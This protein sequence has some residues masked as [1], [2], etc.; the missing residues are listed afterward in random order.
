MSPPAGSSPY[1]VIVRS[2][3][4]GRWRSISLTSGILLTRCHPLPSSIRCSAI[5]DPTAN[6]SYP[7]A[8]R[9]RYDPTF[10]CSSF[11]IFIIII[12]APS[13]NQP[14]PL[15]SSW[16]CITFAQCLR[17][18]ASPPPR[19]LTRSTAFPWRWLT[20]LRSASHPCPSVSPAPGSPPPAPSSESGFP[21][22]YVANIVLSNPSTLALPSSPAPSPSRNY[23]T[24]ANLLLSGISTMGGQAPAAPPVVLIQASPLSSVNSHNPSQTS[25]SHMAGRGTHGRF[26]L[27]LHGPTH[28]EVD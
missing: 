28:Q 2:C 27:L 23:S 20:L 17:C 8:L 11:N 22:L 10:D 1:L 9:L 19:W 3:D 6:K 25:T 24:A 4:F 7:T 5:V 21:A 12:S 13:P 18:S 26:A 14:Y 15:I 16:A